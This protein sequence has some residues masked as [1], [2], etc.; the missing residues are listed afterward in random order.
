MVEC[1]ICLTNDI[2]PFNK[3]ITQCS[4][5]FCKGCLDKWFDRG[6]NTCPMCRK[7]DNYQIGYSFKIPLR[8]V[9]L[10]LYTQNG[11]CWKKNTKRL[12]PI[13]YLNNLLQKSRKI[14]DNSYIYK[15]TK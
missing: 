14:E 3:C 15:W 9:K 2:I 7:T 13:R 6:K 11:C 5:S 1:S 12:R 10:S 8:I 4:H